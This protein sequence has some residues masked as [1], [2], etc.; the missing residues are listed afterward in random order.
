MG[1][2]FGESPCLRSSVW[3][4]MLIIE[5]TPEAMMQ[6][7]QATAAGRT[8]RLLLLPA[9]DDCVKIL[10]DRRHELP[11]SCI[12][13]MPDAET[14]D[15]L[16]D[17]SKFFCWAEAHGFPFPRTIEVT[18]FEQL[19]NAIREIGYPVLL[20]PL[21]RTWLWNH[22]MPNDKVFI[23]ETHKQYERLPRMLFD[24][25]PTM[26]VQQW[27]PG[28][29]DEVYF[30]LVQY[31]SEGKLVNYFSG[32]KLMQ[33]PPLGGSTAIAVS[34]EKDETRDLTV[35]IFDAVKYQGL[36][37]MEYKKDPRN[38]KFYIMEPT[39]GRNDF[40]SYIAV[41][42]GVNLTAAVCREMLGEA[43]EKPRKKPSAW[44]SEPSVGYGLKYYFRRKDYY[45]LKH[46]ALLFR[47]PGFA[48]LSLSDTKPFIELLKD[49][50]VKPVH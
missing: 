38:G 16:L 19:D 4:S 24:V 10:S 18:G 48:Y 41:T 20:K 29:D 21:Y 37:S 9:D 25:A 50:F 17:K 47:N 35:A 6:A 5:R 49:R 7:I 36:G 28:G 42:G 15:M 33:W 34:D 13:I 26:L 46:L 23:L 30:C 32:R 27:I 44:F 1:I 8:G 39:V 40:Q 14:V 2:A 3:S 43:A 12:L 22:E 31:S 11:P 45:I